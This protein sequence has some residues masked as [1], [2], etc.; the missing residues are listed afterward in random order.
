MQQ[1]SWV[2]R[3][4]GLMYG[5]RPVRIA[6]WHMDICGVCGEAVMVTEPRDFGYLQEKGQDND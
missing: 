4:C 6:T 3:R 1:P 5:R 2:C